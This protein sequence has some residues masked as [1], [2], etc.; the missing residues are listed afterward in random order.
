MGLQRD[1][2]RGHWPQE[3]P[4]GTAENPTIGGEQVRHVDDLVSF[5]NRQL[6]LDNDP[7]TRGCNE[8]PVVGRASRA[9]VGGRHVSWGCGPAHAWHDLRA[10]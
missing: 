1:A 8:H 10:A 4:D 7:V 6:G 5:L 9:Q 3:L 2:I